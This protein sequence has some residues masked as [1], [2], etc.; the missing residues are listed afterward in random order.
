MLQLRPGWDVALELHPIKPLHILLLV[1]LNERVELAVRD[2][3]EHPPVC[4]DV[5]HCLRQA[6]PHL[7]IVL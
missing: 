3:I 6:E 4:A 5:L 2:T 7:G 1:G